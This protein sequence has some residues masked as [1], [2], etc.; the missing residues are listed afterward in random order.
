MHR[1]S[2]NSVDDG[3]RVALGALLAYGL[4]DRSFSSSMAERACI[5]CVGV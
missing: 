5:I 2:S 3:M 1:G 4:V